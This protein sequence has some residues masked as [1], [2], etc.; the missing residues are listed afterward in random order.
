MFAAMRTLQIRTELIYQVEEPSS[1]AFSITAAR[2]DHQTVTAERIEVLPDVETTL[3]PYG[4]DTHRLLRFDIAEG[5]LEVRYEAT[6]VLDGGT[7]VSSELAEL[8]FAQIPGDVMTYLNPSRYCESDKLA[9]FAEH[10]FGDVEPGHARVQ[11]VSDWV[12]ENLRYEPGVT[13]GSSSTTD[14][15]LERAG[16]CRDYA[17]VAI[18][19]CR[20]LGI[21]AR[22]VSG[23]GLGVE[24]QDFHGFFEAYLGG[25]WF[26]FDPT[27]MAA[28]DGLV[29]I[30]FGRDAADAPFAA[31]VGSADL[32]HMTVAVE[33]IGQPTAEPEATS[34]A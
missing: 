15:L 16:V 23:Y 5:Q 19:L 30:G 34:T 25:A 4:D 29:R 10:L 2:T 31:F 13:D 26:L 32:V 24:P 20:A 12:R 7:E 21:P 1:F 9:R 17:H 8:E 6:V 33:S 11:T 3:V 27:G 28:I 22:Y 18:S 14:V